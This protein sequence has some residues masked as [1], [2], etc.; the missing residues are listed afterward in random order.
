MLYVFFGFG[1]IFIFE[2][3]KFR[4]GRFEL[5]TNGYLRL[6]TLQST[7]LPLSY[8]RLVETPLEMPSFRKKINLISKKKNAKP[9]L[10]RVPRTFQSA[11]KKKKK[12]KKNFPK[13]MEKFF[14]ISESKN[15]G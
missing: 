8:P 15:A 2:E 14:F 13:E 6:R 5:P 11:K 9:N 12:N 3:K 7:A 4:G 10:E 1:F